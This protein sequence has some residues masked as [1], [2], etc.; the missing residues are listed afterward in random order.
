MA[1]LPVLVSLPIQ[2]YAFL[3]GTLFSYTVTYPYYGYGTVLN[4]SWFNTLYL[5]L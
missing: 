5:L 4:L 2:E 1:N 3:V